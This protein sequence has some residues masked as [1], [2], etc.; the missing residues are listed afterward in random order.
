VNEVFELQTSSSECCSEM[1]GGGRWR[2]SVNPTSTSFDQV[3][4]REFL[5]STL[6]LFWPPSWWLGHHPGSGDWQSVSQDLLPLRI[7]N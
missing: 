5:C 7:W 6:E 2:T 3:L 4:K 1:N